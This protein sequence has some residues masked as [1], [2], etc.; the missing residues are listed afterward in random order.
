MESFWLVNMTVTV[1]MEQKTNEV[2]ELVHMKTSSDNQRSVSL[3]LQRE[4]GAVDKDWRSYTCFIRLRNSQLAF[5]AGRKRKEPS[6][7]PMIR[8]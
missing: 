4:S 2:G 7:T 3:E 6:T 8:E 5:T 1:L